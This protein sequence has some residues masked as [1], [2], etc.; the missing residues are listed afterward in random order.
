MLGQGA[1]DWDQVVTENIQA[2]SGMCPPAPW[3]PNVYCSVYLYS[4]LYAELL[5]YYGRCLCFGTPK[6]CR[7]VYSQL[8]IFLPWS[9]QLASIMYVASTD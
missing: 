7:H 6:G 9:V 8:H 2:G 3:S 4:D 5:L 1:G